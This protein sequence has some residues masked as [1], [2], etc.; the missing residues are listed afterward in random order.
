MPKQIKKPITF[1]YK[2]TVGRVYSVSHDVTVQAIDEQA[3]RDLA[4]DLSDNMD[5]S[6]RLNLNTAE[7]VNVK[8]L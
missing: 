1:K 4:M 3:A 7:V 6:S 5:H 8:K 2:V